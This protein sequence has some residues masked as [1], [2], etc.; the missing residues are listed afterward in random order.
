MGREHAL[1]FRRRLLRISVLA[2]TS[3][4]LTDL[5]ATLDEKKDSRH[6]VTA[7]SRGLDI[8][9]LFTRDVT[10]M[11]NEEIARS[12]GLARSTVTRLTYTLA[13]TKHLVYDSALKKYKLG[14]ATMSW[15]YAVMDSVAGV[16]A[17]SPFLQDFADQMRASTVA[18]NIQAGSEV[19]YVAR[20]SGPAQVQ[21]RTGIGTRLKLWQAA[22][23]RVFWSISDETRKHEVLQEL[24][25]QPSDIRDRIVEEMEAAQAEWDRYG[26]CTSIGA[27]RLGINAVAC[28]CGD[29]SE[30]GWKYVVSCAGM[31]EEYDLETLKHKI[32]PQLK[33]FARFL[34]PKLATC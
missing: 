10:A 31:S 8:L 17:L 18:L 34:A 2:R 16:Q 27:W 5:R 3:N 14:P 26:F 19:I 20:V 32:A 1:H 15:S 4:L 12:T 21:M 7:L 25:N 29:G 11:G 23:G 22:A 33:D 30:N 13:T 9:A 28:P 24:Q 6:F